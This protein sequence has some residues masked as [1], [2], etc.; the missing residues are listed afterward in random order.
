M[1]GTLQI[2][3]R[4]LL[5][6]AAATGGLWL[7]PGAAA[8]PAEPQS[9]RGVALG[10]EA[11][12]VLHHPDAAA[13][14]ALIR[15]SVAEIRRLEAV[16]S[17]YRADSAL[18]VLNREGALAAPPLDLVRL[19]AEARGFSEITGGAF[20]VTVQPLWQLHARH[21]SAPGAD[22]AG[23]PADAIAE[24][25][26]RVDHTAI[27]IRSDRIA[28]GRP[29]MA[30]TLN[31]IA[32][33]YVT[34]RVADLL[35]RAGLDHVLI[36]LGETRALG[37]HPDGRPWRVGLARPDG[38]GDIGRIV[39]LAD[40]AVATSAGHA[41]RFDAAGRHHHLFDPKTGRSTRRHAGVSVIAPTATAADALST[42]LMGIDFDRVKDSLR[43][44]GPLRAVF[45]APD[46]DVRDRTA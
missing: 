34:D 42:G 40:A 41:T 6:I 12:M 19:L 23:P 22:P 28:F 32:Q 25:L 11:S 24:A 4:R 35:R 9:W 29:G 39:D 43:A 37:R 30:V 5:R 33:G 44:L 3:R 1:S 8:R 10:A 26:A 15:R 31:G 13:G 46:G 38:S 14:H 27:T 17:L 36:D 45:T 16:F 7:A 20:D 2:G 21:F 18:S